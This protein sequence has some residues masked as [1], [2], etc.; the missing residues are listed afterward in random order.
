ME[1]QA[2]EDVTHVERVPKEVASPLV[3]S[4]DSMLGEIKELKFLLGKYRSLLDQS[5]KDNES[6]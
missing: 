6:L 1:V 5:Y 2:K 3:R 4:Y